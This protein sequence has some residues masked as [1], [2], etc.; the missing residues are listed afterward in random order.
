MTY[1]RDR[2]EYFRWLSSFTRTAVKGIAR[3]NLLLACLVFAAGILRAQEGYVGAERCGACHADKFAIQSRSN[4]AK[5]LHPVSELVGRDSVPSGS[6]VESP[7]FKGARFDYLKR[8]S[9]YFVVVTLGNRQ[10]RVPIQWV[11]GAGDQGRTFFSHLSVDRYG[12]F[13]LEHRMSYYKSK[14]GFDITTGHPPGLSRSLEKALG[15]DFTPAA[16]FQCFNCHST[17]VKQTASG[18]PDFASVVPGVKCE[19]CHGAGGAHVAAITSGAA[20]T[21]IRNLG[22]LSGKEL[23]RMCGECHRNE[24]APPGMPIEHPIVTR[25]Q[26]VGLQQ[27]ACFQKSGGTITCLT[28]HDP[29]E[30]VRRGDDAFYDARCLTCHSVPSATQCPVNSSDGCIGCHMPRSTPLPYLTFSDHW[31]RVPRKPNS[32]A[33]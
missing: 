15:L 6:V 5:A 19:R 21:R 29:H 18:A 8:K 23:V 4:H 1:D 13:L 33:K 22:R 16:A 12:K 10:R 25:F 17:Y 11:F 30:D 27:S 28:C 24:P 2:M 7:D 26:P 9:D 20:E 32:Q 31:I 3:A 14:N